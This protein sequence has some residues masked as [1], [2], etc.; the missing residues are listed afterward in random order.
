[1]AY[2]FLGLVNDVNTRLN[3]VHLTS[4]NFSNTTGFYQQAKD[5][6]IASIRYINQDEYE[7]PFN[8]VEQED[9]MSANTVRYGFPNDI[10]T[11][12]MDSFRIKRDLS[13]NVITTKLNVILYEEFLDKYLDLEYNSSSTAGVPQYVFRT[14]SFEYGLIPAPDK[15]YSLIYEYYRTPVDLILATDV[16][17]I[18]ERFRHI[19]V[20]G[21]MYYAYLFRNNSQDAQ[22][23]LQ[24]FTTGIKQ[25]RSL[26]INRYEYIR[27]TRRSYKG[28]NI[29]VSTT[30]SPANSAFD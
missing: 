5:A 11:I 21:A 29:R 1:M 2:D 28:S 14:P 7:Y 10:K 8:H 26:T 12:D 9:I 15:A 3:E 4:V 22:I 16:P 17:T 19:I 20:D 27:D 23:S 13:L 6:I 24:K 25:L 30:R 18:P